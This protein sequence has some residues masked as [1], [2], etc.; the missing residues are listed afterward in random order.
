MSRSEHYSMSVIKWA[1][2]PFDPDRFDLD[3]ADR[4]LEWLAWRPF[5]SVS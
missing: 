2:G 3:D 1:G 5:T 4:A